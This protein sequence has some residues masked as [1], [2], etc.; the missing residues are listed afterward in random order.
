MT[1]GF[2]HLVAC[3][4]NGEGSA[5]APAANQYDVVTKRIVN[6]NPALFGRVFG[7]AVP[8]D[9]KPSATELNLAEV[10]ADRRNA[11]LVLAG[12]DQVLHLEFQRRA[13]PTMADR[14]LIYRSLLRI[15]PACVGKRIQQHV[16]VLGEGTSPSRIDEAPDLVFAFETHYVRKLDP[17]KALG[18]PLSAPWAILADTHDSKERMSRLAEVLRAA[19]SVESKS[20]AR[21][22]RMTTLAF[23][24]IVMKREDVERA[25]REAGMPT[26]SSN[27]LVWADEIH[28]EGHAEGVRDSTAKLLVR[29]GVA[30]PEAR[31]IAEALIGQN[32]EAAAERA[33]FDD[34]DELAALVAEQ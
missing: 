22:L 18:D 25:L 28:A 16:I 30:E 33:A 13:D 23:A 12:D 34:L 24:A 19:T 4:A 31:L 9:A 32:P 26:D 29:R 21:D 3:F 5:I 17:S 6:A 11:D 27:D 14:M 7:I 15:E 20:L 1:V 10:H 2:S 8:S